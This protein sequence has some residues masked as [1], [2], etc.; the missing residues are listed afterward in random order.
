MVEHNAYNVVMEKFSK[1]GYEVAPVWLK[2]RGWDLEA[3]RGKQV[4]YIEVKGRSGSDL[5]AEL[6]PKEYKKSSVPG[7][8]ICIVP[9]ALN[10]KPDVY[11][12]AKNAA[13]IWWKER[14]RCALPSLS[15]PAHELARTEKLRMAIRLSQLGLNA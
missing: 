2:N 11:T 7:Y 13:G 12:F 5:V 9:A 1:E 14:R 3:R 10:T 8:R 4:L 15:V 6:T